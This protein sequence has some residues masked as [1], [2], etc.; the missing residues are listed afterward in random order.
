[1]YVEIKTVVLRYL[2]EDKT[3]ETIFEMEFS[4]QEEVSS[5]CGPNTRIALLENPYKSI[6]FRNLVNGQSY[7]LINPL[8]NN[9]MLDQ[10]FRQSSAEMLENQTRFAIRDN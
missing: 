7:N 2:E 9:K 5:F 4:N 3:E 10:K 6:S 8:F 1:M